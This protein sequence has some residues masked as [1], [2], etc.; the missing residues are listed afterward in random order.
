MTNRELF[1]KFRNNIKSSYVNDSCLYKI[2]IYSNNFKDFSDLILN[3]DNK[4]IDEDKATNIFSR[5]NKGEPLE[6]IFNKYIYEDLILYVDKN[7]LIPRE[8]TIE[9]TEKIIS[10]LIKI[11]KRLV[12]CDLCCG[13]GVIGILLAKRLNNIK[14]YATDNRVKAIKIAEKNSI[15]NKVNISF[16]LGDKV[17]PIK[18]NNIRLDFLVSNPPYVHDIKSIDENVLKYE[19]I[20]SIYIKDGTIFYENV[21]K[22]IKKIMKKKF[23]LFFEIGFNQEEKITFLIKKYF[24]DINI[25]YNFYK[26]FYGKT[27]FLFIEGRYK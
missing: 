7:V 9:M 16:L 26:D 4:C 13:S 19:P 6:Y 2:L 25:S 10:K 12:G 14:I 20:N 8:E 27:R 18:R 23:Y 3:F 24:K 22:N 15:N 21:F 17:V 1:F 5:A 11:D